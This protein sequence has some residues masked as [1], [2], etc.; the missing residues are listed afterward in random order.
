MPTRQFT[1]KTVDEAA[2][3]ALGTLNLKREEV[4]IVVVNPGRSGILGL[5][6]EPAVIQVTPL[7]EPEEEAVEVEVDEPQ[8]TEIADGPRERR[9][10]DSRRGR[11]GRGQRQRPGRADSPSD[12]LPEPEPQPEPEPIGVAAGVEST[13]VDESRDEVMQGDEEP[14]R[15]PGPDPEAEALATEI[16]DYFLGVM[17]VVAS[18][19]IREDSS[20]GVVA[21]EIEGEDAGLLIGRRGETLQALQFVVNMLINKQLGRQAYVTVDVEGYRERRYES[22]REIAHRTASRVSS[23]G[24]P[25]PL[26]PMSAA[27]RRIVHMALAD[28]PAVH[29]ESKGEGA[30]RRVV[31]LPN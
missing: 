14:E 12:T 9:E 24:T 4:E 13:A 18:T 26:Q 8:P 25:Q 20:D 23:S 5:G 7:D 2:D 15:Q 21:F 17:G 27:D 10:R 16:L 11:G 6:G 30:E 29:T 31:V 3:L 22:L 28:H 1:G 19:Y